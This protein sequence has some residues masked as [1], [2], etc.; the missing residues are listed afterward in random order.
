MG[1][2]HHSSDDQAPRAEALDSL[3][4]FLAD[5][6]SFAEDMVGPSEAEPWGRMMPATL[7]ARIT[8]LFFRVKAM[9]DERGMRERIAEHRAAERAAS[10][11]LF[12]QTSSLDGY[13]HG[14]HHQGMVMMMMSSSALAAATAGAVGAGAAILAAAAAA[15]EDLAIMDLAGAAEDI[16]RLFGVGS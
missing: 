3:E 2:R 1:Q 8:G 5:V 4:L 14:N 13:E 16:G 6:E 11:D 10:G 7:G 9:I 15:A 12:P